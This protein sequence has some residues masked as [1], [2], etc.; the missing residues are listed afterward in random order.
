[1]ATAC[2]GECGAAGN[3]LEQILPAPLAATWEPEAS[4]AAGVPGVLHAAG[5]QLLASASGGVPGLPE[6]QD[7]A[8]FAP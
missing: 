1:M 3:V 2:H 5:V 7:W 8:P 6:P 4:R